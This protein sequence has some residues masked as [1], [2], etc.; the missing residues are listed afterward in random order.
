MVVVVVSPTPPAAAEARKPTTVGDALRES[1]G[2]HWKVGCHASPLRTPPP[3]PVAAAVLG[4]ARHTPAAKDAQWPARR[5]PLEAAKPAGVAEVLLAADGGNRILEGLVTNFFVVVHKKQKPDGAATPLVL[6]APTDECLPG[7]A[8]AAVFA[9]CAAEGLVVEERAPRASERETWR[10]A[11]VT[12]TIRL[13][14]P[15]WRVSWPRGVTT[16][17]EEGDRDVDGEEEVTL[18]LPEAFGPVTR[19]ILS[20]VVASLSGDLGP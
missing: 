19:T 9:A 18:Q 12:N 14:H 6:T 11:F 5:A 8:R 10:E 3:E 15:V 17:L 16:S 1:G 13:V 2:G 4:P 20:R 7:L